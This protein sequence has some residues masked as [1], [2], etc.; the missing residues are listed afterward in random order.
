MTKQSTLQELPL[1]GLEV[2]RRYTL[3]VTNISVNATLQFRHCGDSTYRTHP[4]FTGTAASN[5]IMGEFVCVSTD[6]KLV[7]ASAPGGTYY[8]SAVQHTAATF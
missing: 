6:V 7:F 5:V 8:V 1:E 3:V 4:S 2:G